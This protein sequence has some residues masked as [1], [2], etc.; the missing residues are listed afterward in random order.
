MHIVPTPTD[1]FLNPQRDWTHNRLMVI[2][3]D[4]TFENLGTGSTYSSEQA[5]G[6]DYNGYQK[7]IDQMPSINLELNDV[8]AEGSPPMTFYYQIS[9]RLADKDTIQKARPLSFFKTHNVAQTLTL[10]GQ[11]AA[12]LT[13]ASY[14]DR[15]SRMW[16]SSLWPMNSTSL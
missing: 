1:F 10:G 13:Y 15:D 16:Y 5:M 7:L 6:Q 4:W 2:H 8:R 12:V 14:Y 3:G 9:L 11:S